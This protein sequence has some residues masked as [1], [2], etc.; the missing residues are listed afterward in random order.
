MGLFSKGTME[1]QL[2]KYNFKPGDE[3]TGKVNIKLK[4]PTEGKELFV[5]FIGTRIDK[6]RTSSGA[7]GGG[8]NHKSGT[9]T[10]YTTVHKFK[11]PLDGEKEY[12]E[13]SY[14][15]NIMIPMDILGSQQTTTTNEMS[16][17]AQAG[18]AVMRAIAGGTTHTDSRLKFEI[19]ARLDMPGF[20]MKKDQDITIT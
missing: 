13:G 18:V 2:D 7:V 10:K 8:S 12:K 20:D 4:K 14:D 9:Q 6:F 16:E 1:L 15:F 11:M 19:K 5:E 3:I 17:G